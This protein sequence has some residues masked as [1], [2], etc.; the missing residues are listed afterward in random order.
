MGRAEGR[1]QW[2]AEMAMIATTDIQ[3]T[4]HKL[5]HKLA[6]EY[7]PEKVILFGS[8][9]YGQPDGDSDLDMI[10]QFS[11]QAAGILCGA[12]SASL[13]GETLGGQPIEGSDSIRP[14][15]CQ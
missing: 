15:G 8:Y 5:V 2:Y 12:T 7:A 9:A 4:L 11:T 6:A 1:G 13:T 10:L 3:D 14:V